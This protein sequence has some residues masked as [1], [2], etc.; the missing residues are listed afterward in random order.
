VLGFPERW[1]GGVLALL[2]AG[3]LAAGPHGSLAADESDPTD[4]AR[5]AIARGSSYLIEQQQDDGAWEDHVGITAVA[6][7]ALVAGPA[8]PAS[9]A[10]VARGLRYVEL[11]VRPEGGIYQDESLK[12]YTTSVALLALAA[13]G[14]PKHERTIASARDF[15]VGLQA[16]EENGFAPTHP[17]FGGTLIGGGKANLDATFFAMRAL[18]VAGLPKAHP[19]WE[20]ALRFVARCQ[21]WKLANDQ[22]WAVTDGGFVFAPGFSFAGGT[23]SYGSMTYAG[24]SAYL[25]AGLPRDDERVEAAFRW[26]QSRLTVRENPGLEQ[27]ALFHSYFYL[28]QTLR[29]WAVETIRDG[30][31]QPRS[32]RGELAA[33]LVGR[34][35]ADGSWANT[36]DPRW[37]EGKP[38]LATSFAVR[39]LKEIVDSHRP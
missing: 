3:L 25:D 14:D 6:I 27:Q 1:R 11:S 30:A 20:R 29:R 23:T 8:E 2:A 17:N 21:N 32:W 12:H 15:L 10:A 24:L 38:V 28:S 39:T 34:Q 22:P 13:S 16:R 33:A 26:V 37:W 36:A 4:A 7:L 18:A 9:K 19:Y 31:G 35:R 5:A